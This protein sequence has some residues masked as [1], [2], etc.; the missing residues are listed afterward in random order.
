MPQGIPV[1]QAP[2]TRLSHGGTLPI[3]EEN[4]LRPSFYLPVVQVQPGD[5]TV[6]HV[7]LVFNQ[8]MV[9]KMQVID[10][11]QSGD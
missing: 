10:E 7:I 4:H 11:N 3:V 9:T 6:R 8:P 5:I 2:L 1:A